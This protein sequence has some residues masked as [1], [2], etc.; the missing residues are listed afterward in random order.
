MV[1]LLWCIL[2]RFNI[3]V[4]EEQELHSI[5][6]VRSHLLG[7]QRQRYSRRLLLGVSRDEP[8]LSVSFFSAKLLQD[9][10]LAKIEGLF[11]LHKTL[12][13]NSPV[14]VWV[15]DFTATF[16]VLVLILGRC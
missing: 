16:A 1:L 4:I 11:P 8:E 14:V 6:H 10:T 5:T 12:K 15:G 9:F 2:E 13:L 3:L 7:T